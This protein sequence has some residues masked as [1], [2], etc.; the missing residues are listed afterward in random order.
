MSSAVS[1]FQPY[2]FQRKTISCWR[3]GARRRNKLLSP[4]Y[5]SHLVQVCRWYRAAWRRMES[6]WCQQSGGS[7]ANKLLINNELS[8]LSW[9]GDRQRK[10]FSVVG[11][12]LWTSFISY[13]LRTHVCPSA[14]RRW[15]VVSPRGCRDGKCAP[16]YLD[17]DKEEEDVFD[18]QD[19]ISV[20]LRTTSGKL[21]PCPSV[22]STLGVTMWSSFRHLSKMLVFEKTVLPDY[23]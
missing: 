8:D 13:L 21:K 10:Q 3:Q 17:D 9:F 12:T 4:R 14:P 20:A 2:H 5:G 6:L 18:H 16:L 22:V 19:R 15:K 23:R 11:G 1:L 7:Q